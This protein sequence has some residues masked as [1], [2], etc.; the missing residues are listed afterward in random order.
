[1]VWYG[2]S[3]LIPADTPRLPV[4]ITVGQWW[5]P[6]LVFA[7]RETNGD[8]EFTVYAV[9]A[10]KPTQRCKI[11]AGLAPRGKWHRLVV[12]AAYGPGPAREVEAFLGDLQVCRWQGN[13]DDGKQR[14][15]V[16][17]LGLYRPTIGKLPRPHPTQVVFFRDIRKGA[18]RTNVE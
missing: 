13:A 12:R 16:W 2:Y 14:L 15:P 6:S 7:L 10:T 5:S 18:E 8:L 11:G 17:K 3:L 1:V 9:S 4:H